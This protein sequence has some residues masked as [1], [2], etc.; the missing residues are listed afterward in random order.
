MRLK[1]GD[2]CTAFVVWARVFWPWVTEGFGR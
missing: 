2:V 1:V